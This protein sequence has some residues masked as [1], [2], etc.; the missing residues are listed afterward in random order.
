MVFIKL[1]L[2]LLFEHMTSSLQAHT[3]SLGPP[4]AYF[5]IRTLKPQVA[6]ASTVASV[7]RDK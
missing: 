4:D 3:L 6:K 1:L 7:M 5:R 2:Q